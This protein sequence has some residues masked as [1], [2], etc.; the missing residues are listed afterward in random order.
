MTDLIKLRKEI[1]SGI[2]SVFVR[3]GKI[4][5]ED[6]ESGECIIIA[7]LEEAKHG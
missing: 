1:K 4:Y 6:T 5:I 3:R 7:D 2:F